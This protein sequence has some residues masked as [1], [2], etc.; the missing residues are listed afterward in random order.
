VTIE[1]FDYT[2]FVQVDR[3]PETTVQWQ[4][5]SSKDWTWRD[6]QSASARSS[7][8][9]GKGRVPTDGGVLHHRA[10]VTSKVTALSTS[11]NPVPVTGIT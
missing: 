4:Q 5:A 3:S 9:H 1:G 6:V 10:V 8:L 2:A 7:T 11:S